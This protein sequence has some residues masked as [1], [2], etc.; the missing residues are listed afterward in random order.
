MHI[1]LICKDIC[2]QIIVVMTSIFAYLY[3][4]HYYAHQIE[5]KLLHIRPGLP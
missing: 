5:E 2:L 1:F 3:K 4:Q